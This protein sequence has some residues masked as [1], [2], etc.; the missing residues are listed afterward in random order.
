MLGVGG[1]EL[2]GYQRFSSAQNRLPDH[3]HTHCLEICLLA[4][5]LQYFALGETPYWMRGGQVFLTFPGETHSTGDQPMERGEL[6]WLLVDLRPRRNFLGLGPVVGEEFRRNLSGSRSRLF[7]VPKETFTAMRQLKRELGKPDVR[8]SRLVEALCCVMNRI[9]AASC[10]SA[11]VRNDRFQT[12]FGFIEQNLHNPLSVGSLARRSGL[13]ESQFK[14]SFK[15]A[16]GVPPGEFVNRRRVER[17]RAL[18]RETDRSVTEIALD[19][20]FST[21]QY[22]ASVFR[23]ITGITP[24][25]CRRGEQPPVAIP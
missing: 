25:Q 18:L 9:I 11:T 4:R 19:L 1:I 5:G 14:A 12:V 20:G 7:S 3:E 22:F 17:A 13:S 21:P 16:V 23:R 10:D 15:E 8:A 6:F 24:G 2:L